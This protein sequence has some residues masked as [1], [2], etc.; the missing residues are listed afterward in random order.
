[1]ARGIAMCDVLREERLDAAAGVFKATK[2]S[3]ARM[4]VLICARPFQAVSHKKT[5]SMKP[6]SLKTGHRQRLQ[7]SS[8]LV[9]RLIRPAGTNADAVR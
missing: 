6:L 8:S 1:M 5:S 3:S 9:R 4:C 7:R 2:V